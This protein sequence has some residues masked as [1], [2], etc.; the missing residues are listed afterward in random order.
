MMAATYGFGMGSR[1]LNALVRTLLL[2]GLGPRRTYLLT[3]IDRRRG[4]SYSTPV[5]LVEEGTNR[6]V[7]TPYGEVSWV[8]N[9]RAAGQAT[10][11]YGRRSKTVPVVERG[12]AES[13]PVFK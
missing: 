3:V 9:A 8:G 13:A 7:V 10:L 6:W 5:T 4:K 2:V 12:P 11:S 1:L